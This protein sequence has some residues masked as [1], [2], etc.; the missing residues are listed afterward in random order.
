MRSE[1]FASI[2]TPS[3]VS[4]IRRNVVKQR[5][6]SREVGNKKVK[7]HWQSSH[8][9]CSRK[10]YRETFE[11]LFTPRRPPRKRACRFDMKSSVFLEKEREK[12][13]TQ[14]QKDR[15]KARVREMCGREK[16]RAVEKIKRMGSK[17][18]IEGRG[19]EGG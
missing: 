9:L 18:F 17:D 2:E 4:I 16:R 3:Q 12:R 7:Q 6:R 19:F 11:E 1:S 14:A 13:V 8:C 15:L 5:F 10:P